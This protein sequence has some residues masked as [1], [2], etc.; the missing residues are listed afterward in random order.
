[1][2]A[3]VCR[4]YGPPNVLEYIAWPDPAPQPGEI[5]LQ[6]EAVGV[7]FVDTMRRSGRHPAPPALPFIPGIELCGT[8]A[9]LG[10]DVSGFRLGQRVIGRCITH[11]ASAELVC[12]EARFAVP[13]P[14]ELPASTAAG[15][16]VVGQTAFHALH[17]AGQLAAG[18]TV[19]VTAAAGGVGLCAVQLARNAGATVIAAAGSERKL[20]LAADHGA[21]V[22]VNYREPGW[23]REVLAATGGQ[24]ATLIVESVGGEVFQEALNCW[25]PGGRMVIYGEAS[26]TPGTLTGDCLLFGNR[27]ARGLAVGTVIED[28]PLMRSA[29]RALFECLASGTL[30]LPVDRELPLAETA[31]AHE[32]L[33]SRQTS[34]KLILLP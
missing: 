8:V 4:Q 15:L 29:M 27:S 16:F 30:H 13:C 23:S 12:V 28:E 2:Q 11:G 25:A 17:T 5:L 20:Q 34:G 21:S 10:A 3:A 9:A 1:M 31:R 19:L 6:A 18:E 7:N 32:L 26:G 33:E 22:C 14:V 24:G